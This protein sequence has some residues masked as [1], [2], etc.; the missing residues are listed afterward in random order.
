MKEGYIWEL[1][2]TLQH[3]S[4]KMFNAATNRAFSVIAVRQN[5][6]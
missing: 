4:L 6:Q 2:V 3:N 1:V 5:K